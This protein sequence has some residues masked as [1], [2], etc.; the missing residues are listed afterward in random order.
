MK[1]WKL[2]TLTTLVMILL[3]G[4]AYY[5]VLAGFLAYRVDSNY[6]RLLVSIYS[7]AEWFLS[8][9]LIF[10]GNFVLLTSPIILLVEGILAA[11][12][13][14]AGAWAF[15]TLYARRLEFRQN[16]GR[17]SESVQGGENPY[18]SPRE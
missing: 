9:H 12:S 6:A 2:L 1:F 5:V 4:L 13:V 14:R 7:E 18:V 10:D 8:P 11:L 16:H 17:N 3:N 15:R